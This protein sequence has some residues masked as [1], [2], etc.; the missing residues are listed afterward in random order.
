VRNLAPLDEVLHH[1]HYL[2]PLVDREVVRIP[3]AQA[4]EA[5][6]HHQAPRRLIPVSEHELLAL[7][8]QL[9]YPRIGHHRRH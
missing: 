3:G 8:Q 1:R 6:Q 2:A 7:A 9:D 5:T 4:D